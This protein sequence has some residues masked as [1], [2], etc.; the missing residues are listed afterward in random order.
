VLSKKELQLIYCLSP[1]LL[2]DC[3]HHNVTIERPKMSVFKII[4]SYFELGADKGDRIGD[5]HLGVNYDDVV[6][7]ML[8][9]GSDDYQIAK[10]VNSIMDKWDIENI[11][12]L[13]I[14]RHRFTLTRLLLHENNVAYNPIYVKIGIEFDSFD[15]VYLLKSMYPEIYTELEK[16]YLPSLLLSFQRSNT[17]WLAKLSMLKSLINYTNYIKAES[18]LLYTLRALEK[19]DVTQNPMY[20]APNLLLFS[21]SLIEICRIFVS[22]YDFLGAYTE[23]IEEILVN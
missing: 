19:V 18:F 3:L 2:L 7:V 23:K 21:V 15:I 11:I 14:M 16:T 10:T 12:S 6:E 22:K 4:S 8:D 20:Y 13:C 5:D 1:D 17:F 9:E